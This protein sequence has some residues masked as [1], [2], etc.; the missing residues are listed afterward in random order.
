MRLAIDV[1]SGDFGPRTSVPACMMALE[2]F[3]FLTLDLVGDP[4]A[5]QAYTSSLY[6]HRFRIVS[7]ATTI[8]QSASI[9]EALR[10]A[11]G[12]SMRVALE[13]VSSGLADGAVSA[14]NTGALVALSC[15]LIGCLEGIKRPAIC[16]QLPRKDGCFFLLDCGANLTVS[17]DQLHEFAVM[18]DA[19]A[20]GVGS[21]KTPRVAL[22]NVG[23]EESKGNPVVRGAADKIG[24]NKSICFD[25]FIEGHELFDSSVDVIVCDGFVGN[26]ALKT[27]EGLAL[28]L[29]DR[30]SMSVSRGWRRLFTPLT[31]LLLRKAVNWLNPRRYNGASLLG[32]SKV[33]VKSHGSA[34]VEAFYA[35]IDC[36]IREVNAKLPQQIES[37]ISQH[38]T[39]AN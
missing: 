21:V 35:A 22:L 17:A 32:L 36:A 33:V 30:V 38:S 29:R 15:K 31:K 1:M 23:S 12:S 13:Q 34:N 20:R 18:G 25:G 8:T 6:H 24:A 7:A 37:Q 9:G 11:V 27:T 5:I 10:G 28:H 16:A 14:G 2:H 39:E 3:P 4:Q 19:L 26:V